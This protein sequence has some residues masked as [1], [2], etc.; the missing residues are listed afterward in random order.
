MWLCWS[1]EIFSRMSMQ[2]TLPQV[3]GQVWSLRG[4]MTLQSVPQDREHILAVR[5]HTLVWR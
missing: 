5:Y 1:L 4:Q 3:E 2:I